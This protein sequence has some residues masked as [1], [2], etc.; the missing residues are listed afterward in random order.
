[1]NILNSIRLRYKIL[2]FPAVFVLVVALIFTTNKE[3][4]QQIRAELDL[5]Q[6]SYIPYNEYTT[7]MK[8]TQ[9][10]IQKGL[11][12]AVAAMDTTALEKTEALA[13]TF[14]ALVDSAKSVKNDNDYE[15]L[16][17]TLSSFNTYFKYGY[18]ASY[19]MIQED[20]SDAVTQ[21]VQAMI[22]ELEILKKNLT[23]ISGINVDQAFDEARNYLTEQSDTVNNVLFISLAFFIGISVI[24]SQAIVGALKKTVNSIQRLSDGYLDVQ[25]QPS[26]LK[27]RDEIGDISKA[28][29]NLVTQ[30]RNVILGVQAESMEISQI[31][32]SLE[33][34]SHQMASSS[35]EQAEF[36]E[37]ISSTMEEVTRTI[38]MNAENAAE[39][40]TISRVANTQLKEVEEKSK[41]AIAANENITNRI[42][43]ISDIA[44]QTNILALN[45]AIEAARA[46]DAGKGFAVVASEVQM[47]AEKSKSVSDEIVELTESAYKM[48][49]LAGEVM[50]DTIPKIDK[51]SNLV[52]EISAASDEQSKG[53]NQVNKSIQHLNSLA[54]QSAASSE[55]LA[56]SADDLLRQSNRLKDAISYYKLDG[57]QA[58]GNSRPLPKA[59]LKRPAN[60]QKEEELDTAFLDF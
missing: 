14:R 39:T 19:L 28:L 31:S 27:R 25:V 2:G 45:A 15:A 3:S 11:Q 21:N 41:M 17:N 51:T 40:N 35:N 23:E 4:S 24:L 34:T 32:Q 9:V 6:Y 47:L 58:P 46:G 59:E 38:N 43:Q 20:Y 29:D 8:A 57:V 10:A 53:A 7:S 33:H 49:S 5:V 56:A 16:D 12:D 48:S 54:Q 30:L 52:N 55:E 44:F 50:F 1:M 37:E 42:N 13:S 26:F 36:V 22:S 18:Q 60:F